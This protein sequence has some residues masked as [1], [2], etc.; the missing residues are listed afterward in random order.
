MV[1]REG[2]NERKGENKN[3]EE[4][5]GRWGRRETEKRKEEQVG[6]RK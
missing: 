3:E 1:L 2:R 6:I 4:A 5:G